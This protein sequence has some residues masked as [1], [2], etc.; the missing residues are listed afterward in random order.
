M[1]RFVLSTLLVASACSPAQEPAPPV[2]PPRAATQDPGKPE[3]GKPVDP[4]AQALL[5]ELKKQL[6]QEGI[7]YDAATGTVAVKAV[8]NQ[9]QDP[10]EYLLIHR[11]G[12]RHE[13]MFVTKC[14]PSVLNAALLLLGLK[15]GTNASYKE[16]DP[17]PTLEEVQNGADPV[18]VTPPKG[19]PFWMTVRWK[20]GE[21]TATGKAPIVEHCVEDLILD[22]TTGLPIVDCSWVYL[23]G[24]LAQLYRDEP[25][26][27]IADFEG[28][29]I[30]TCYMAPDNHLGTVVHA[31]ARDDQNWWLTNLV[32]APDTEVEFVFHARMPKV[33]EERLQ[34]LAKAK[35]NPP[36]VD[37]KAPPAG[38]G[39][40]R[41]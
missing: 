28:N 9:P 16:K 31:Q 5:D 7:T 15:A 24:R 6:Q 32:P 4:K 11:K 12:K 17:A 20:N 14:K 38:E 19:E 29:L 35:A 1:I 40:Q 26:V 22:R 2:V 41:R 34:R 33:H 23:G 21:D 36:A 37:P 30:S 8:V 13:A 39:E 27:F 10:I 18:V 25:E 3:P